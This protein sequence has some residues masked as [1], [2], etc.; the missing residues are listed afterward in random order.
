MYNIDNIDKLIE[1][2][3]KGYR[4]TD[5]DIYNIYQSSEYL[6]SKPNRIN[7]IN[8]LAANPVLV[9]TTAYLGNNPDVFVECLYINKSKGLLNFVAG[10]YTTSCN[11]D[12]TN[13]VFKCLDTSPV[14]SYP[15][16]KFR[17]PALASFATSFSKAC[18]KIQK[19][20]SGE[21]CDPANPTCTAWTDATTPI[22]DITVNDGTA[23]EPS[24]PTNLAITPG[25]GSL[26][27]KWDAV[28]NIPIFAYRV[29]IFSPIGLIKSGYYKSDERNVTITGLQNETYTIEV[30]GRSV[31]GMPGSPSTGTG[32]PIAS[33]LDCKNNKCVRIAGTGTD[34]CTPEDSSCGTTEKSSNTALIVGGVIVLGAASYYFVSKSKKKK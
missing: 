31:N 3:R 22:L 12:I 29:S 28:T 9:S 34:K 13:S 1:L 32:I 15:S 30:A 23:T 20:T 8:T 25:L 14:D 11:Y 5:D 7:R 21:V 4:Y 10:Q 24:P 2:Y 18:F 19:C 27:I 33:H 26:N 16:M 17:A 6:I